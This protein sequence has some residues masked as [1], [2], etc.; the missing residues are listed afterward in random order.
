MTPAYLRAKLAAQYLGVS[1]SYFD[2]HIAHHVPAHDLTLPGAKKRLRVWYVADLDAW[3][4][5]RKVA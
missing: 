1:R 2:A 3:M 5:A 4:A